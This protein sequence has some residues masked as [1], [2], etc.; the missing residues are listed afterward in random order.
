MLPA[1]LL[2]GGEVAVAAVVLHDDI[3]P[4]LLSPATAGR[5]T[6]EL[7][8]GPT[9]ALALV[10][11]HVHR[12]AVGGHRVVHVVHRV[13]QNTDRGHCSLLSVDLRE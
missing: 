6:A 1:H 7:G 8:Q 10:V 9:H 11:E 12:P 4:G 3:V 13:Q 2:H 5:T